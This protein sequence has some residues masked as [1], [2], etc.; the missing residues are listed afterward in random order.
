MLSTGMVIVYDEDWAA[1][2]NNGK[3]EVQGDP[4]YVEEH[5]FRLLGVRQHSSDNLI[6]PLNSGAWDTLTELETADDN[7]GN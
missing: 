3:L 6:N 7:K 5:V 2:Y 1:F 4:Y